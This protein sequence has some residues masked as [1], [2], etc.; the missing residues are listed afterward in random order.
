MISK[1]FYIRFQKD[2]IEIF[3][4]KWQGECVEKCPKL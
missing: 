2:G 3:D 4:Q 1:P